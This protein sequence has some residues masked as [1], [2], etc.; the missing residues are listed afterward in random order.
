[1]KRRRLAGEGAVVTGGE[2]EEDG[3]RAART[4]LASGLPDAVVT[5]N[6]RSAVGLLDVFA[7]EDVAVPGAISVVGYDDSRIARRA[8]LQLTTISQDIER[9]AWVAVQQAAA[10]IEGGTP[11]QREQVLL[12]HLVSRSSTAPRRPAG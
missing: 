12:P 6:D 9:L 10:R 11:T 4:L 7:R 3:A 1:M 8:Y 2:G 5:Y